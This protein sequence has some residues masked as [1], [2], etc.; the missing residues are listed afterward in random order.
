MSQI[1][2]FEWDDTNEQ[3]LLQRHGVTITETEEAFN[4]KSFY[5]TGRDK[6]KYCLGQTD[7]GRYLFMVYLKKEKGK[8]RVISARDMSEKERKLYKRKRL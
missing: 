1:R 2:E 6:T 3:H 4:R 5:V 8:I 7:E